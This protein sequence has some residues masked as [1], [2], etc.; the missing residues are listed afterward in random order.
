M[1]N[2][3]CRGGAL[4]DDA[5]W[6]LLLL[7]FACSHTILE[8]TVQSALANEYYTARAHLYGVFFNY[9][10]VMTSCAVC[11]SWFCWLTLRCFST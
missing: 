9:I 8:L 7:M 11:A 6:F 1:V 5:Q 4:G 10:Q 2:W 3:R